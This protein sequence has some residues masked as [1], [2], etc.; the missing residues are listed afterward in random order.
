VVLKVINSQTLGEH[1]EALLV[2]EVQRVWTAHQR[3]MFE[4][5]RS[6]R[7]SQV[8]EGGRTA[9]RLPFGT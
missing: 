2:L 1:W 8:C 5:R 7:W 3:R 4:G 6:S 9:G